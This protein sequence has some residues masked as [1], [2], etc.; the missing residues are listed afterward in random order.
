[1]PFIVVAGQL[2]GRPKNEASKFMTTMTYHC[3][4]LPDFHGH[5]GSRILVAR[6]RNCRHRDRVGSLLGFFRYGHLPEPPV[7]PHVQ[8]EAK[9]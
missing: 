5:D 2:S 6:G 8:G 9:V 7:I 3:S 1:M 4:R